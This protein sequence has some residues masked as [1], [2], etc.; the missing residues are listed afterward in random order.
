[1]RVINCLIGILLAQLCTAQQVTRKVYRTPGGSK[2][3]YYVLASDP[4]T[5][6]GRY[7]RYDQNTLTEG[8]YKNG[9]QDGL[10]TE[11]FTNRTK[12]IRVQ[13]YFKD[14]MRNG[15]WT[16]YSSRKK[17]RSKGSYLD[18]QKTNFW[19]FF[20]DNGEV[21]E[22]GYFTKD[23]RSGKWSFYDE[24]GV[25]VQ[26]YDYT[27]KNVISDVT[28]AGIQPREYKVINGADTTMYFLQRPPVYIG[29]RSKLN[30][31]KII[32]FKPEFDSVKVEVRFII[33]KTG[34]ARDYYI[35]KK[36]GYPFDQ[37][38]LFT[39]QRLPAT[40]A[41][42]MLNGEAVEVEHSLTVLFKKVTMKQDPFHFYQRYL[43]PDPM[44][45][46]P[47]FGRTT[48]TNVYSSGLS[49]NACQVEIL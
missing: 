46:A 38:A 2:E 45:M 15:I 31:A 9:L 8:F 5:L 44:G 3:V 35:V 37:E 36:M 39:L 18:D 47:G 7:K 22:E 14:G 27:N 41:P 43:P 16:V 25:M 11:Y 32:Q 48:I 10:W 13:G 4:N 30:R 20:N 12:Y 29:G 40:W 19:R 34:H 42:A 23:V 49:Y 6:H 33:E 21:T 28:L 26:E 24:K 17:L 1:M